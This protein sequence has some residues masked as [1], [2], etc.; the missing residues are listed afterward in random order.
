MSKPSSYE[1]VVEMSVL[2]GQTVSSLAKRK[3]IRE[4]DQTLCLVSSL[5]LGAMDIPLG[6]Y[7]LPKEDAV[8]LP[9]LEIDVSQCGF[10]KTEYPTQSQVLHTMESI[11]GP[12]ISSIDLYSGEISCREREITKEFLSYL[13]GNVKEVTKE[14]HD[15]DGI[16]LLEEKRVDLSACE[17]L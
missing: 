12:L 5:L 14:F 3:A 10:S 2:S 11:V 7:D 1:E 15:P 4:E 17:K 8:V 9:S 16:L 13:S 6:L